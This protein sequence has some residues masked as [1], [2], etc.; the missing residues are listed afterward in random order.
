M[1][2][3]SFQDAQKYGFYTLGASCDDEE[4]ECA[5]CMIGDSDDLNQILFCD[6]CN[7]AVHQTCYGVRLIPEGE[8]YCQP[9][10]RDI[11]PKDAVCILCGCS[12]GPLKLTVDDNWVHSQCV[13][14][15]NV[16]KF[17]EP[18]CFGRADRKSVV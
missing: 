7:V 15:N 4:L 12:G 2:K 9:C 6:R 8:W 10:E 13:L 16:Y 1:E 18:D 17:L 11:S 14:W 3:T 5:V